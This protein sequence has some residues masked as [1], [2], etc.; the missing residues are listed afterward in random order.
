MCERITKPARVRACVRI[1]FYFVQLSARARVH[2]L[3]NAG[4]ERISHAGCVQVRY[5]FACGLHVCPSDMVS[6]RVFTHKP[7]ACLRTSR[8]NL[9]AELEE[10]YTQG[11]RTVVFGL[12]RI[13][14]LRD[15]VWGNNCWPKE[16]GTTGTR[17][18]LNLF[19]LDVSG[20]GSVLR[21]G[22]QLRKS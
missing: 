13:T 9:F 12:I 17:Q 2:N 3:I 20:G 22:F 21:A 7:M 10:K 1:D 19:Q 4:R 18:P 15:L 14:R 6:D 5:C 16:R 8:N 11:A